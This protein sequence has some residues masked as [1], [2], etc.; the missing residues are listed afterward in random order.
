MVLDTIHARAADGGPVLSPGGAGGEDAEVV[1][2][3]VPDVALE[4]SGRT[5]DGGENA[6]APTAAGTGTLYITTKCVCQCCVV[7]PIAFVGNYITVACDYVWCMNLAGV[8]CGCMMMHQR[9]ATLL[10]IPTSRCM[11]CAEMSVH[12]PCRVCTAR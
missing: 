1:K 5:T 11:Q 2:C 12:T 10:T 6:V 9:T 4:L 7:Q 3:T 8:W